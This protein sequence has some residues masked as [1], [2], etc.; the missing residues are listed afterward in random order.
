[1]HVQSGAVE[2]FGDPQ[3]LLCGL[4]QLLG[5]GRVGEGPGDVAGHGGERRPG[6]S[7]RFDVLCGPVPDFDLEVEVGDP[8]HPLGER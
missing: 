1:M 6:L 3:A 7:Q 5:A 8:A 4:E 2:L